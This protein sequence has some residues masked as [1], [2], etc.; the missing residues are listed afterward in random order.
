MPLD[1]LAHLAGVTRIGP[2][3]LPRIATASPAELAGAAA[4]ADAR[5]RRLVGER[6]DLA[7]E[8]RDA[9]AADPD[10]SVVKAVTPHPGLS[11]ELLRAMVARHGVR[12]LARVAANPDAPPALLEPIPRCRSV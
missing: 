7:P 3:L 2:V 10:A 9:L 11:E 12:V 1:V 5:V 8:L 4:S 6:R